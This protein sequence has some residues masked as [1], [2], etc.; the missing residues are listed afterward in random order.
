MKTT[1]S[2]VATTNG[3][4]IIEEVQQIKGA[5]RAIAE[6]RY[7]KALELLGTHAREFPRGTLAPERI[8]SLV[9]TYCALDRRTNARQQVFQNRHVLEIVVP[10]GK[11]RVCSVT[12]QVEH[13]DGFITPAL[14]NCSD[15]FELT[16]VG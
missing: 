4:A 11:T 10:I 5:R 3:A 6:R 13:Q 15:C 7:G 2:S 8:A 9:E 1:S 14:C 12:I 16:F